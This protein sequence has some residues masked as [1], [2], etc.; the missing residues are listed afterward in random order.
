MSGERND[1]RVRGGGGGAEALYPELMKFAQTA[2]LRLL[3]TITAADV[4]NLDR[5]R[6]VDQAVFKAAR[7]LPAVSSGRRV[8][9]RPPL[10]VKVY[11]SFCTTS[12]VSPTLF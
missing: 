11:I 9:E 12:V 7:T 1:L 2:G 10:S 4:A 5:Q 8:I 3:I 6:T